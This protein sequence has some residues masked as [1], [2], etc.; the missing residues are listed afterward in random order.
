MYLTHDEVWTTRYADCSELVTKGGNSVKAGEL[1]AKVGKAGRVTDPHLHF[2]VR[3][4]G[5]PAIVRAM[6]TE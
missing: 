4:N 1:I 2:E 3:G 6:E 5:R